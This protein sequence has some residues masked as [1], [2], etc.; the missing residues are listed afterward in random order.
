MTKYDKY[1]NK[2]L[3]HSLTHHYFNDT[4]STL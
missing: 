4:S 1:D 2:T 3:I